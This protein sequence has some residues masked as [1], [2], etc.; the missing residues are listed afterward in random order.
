ML[1]STFELNSDVP[2]KFLETNFGAYDYEREGTR[3]ILRNARAIEPESFMP[4]SVEIFPQLRIALERFSYDGYVGNYHSWLEYGKW[5]YDDLI[6]NT[7]D[8][9]QATKDMVIAMTANCATS[10]EKA[11]CIYRYVQQ[12]TRYISIQLGIGGWKPMSAAQV[13]KLKYGDCKALTNYTA[14]LLAVVGIRSLYT[15]VYANS[16]RPINYL[17]DFPSSQGNHV[18]LCLPDL[19]DTTWLECTSNT[20]DFGYLGSFTA[21]RKGLAIGP[22][23]GFIICTPPHQAQP[24]QHLIEINTDRHTTWTRT[25][26]GD[27]A[28]AYASL[29]Q[30]SNDLQKKYLKDRYAPLLSK[31]TLLD[32]D[33]YYDR[34][35]RT[36]REVVSA[37]AVGFALSGPYLTL[38]LNEFSFDP[39]FHDMQRKRY[40]AVVEMDQGLTMDYRIAMPPGYTLGK[41][42]EDINLRNKC[43]SFE[44]V[45]Y[46]QDDQLYL[47]FAYQIKAGRYSG[48]DMHH[49]KELIDQVHADKSV[50]VIFRKRE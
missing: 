33:I 21:N 24:E 12:T 7:R 22:E 30:Y 8:L 2:A 1:E 14:A 44:R 42:V 39:S 10:A 47:R 40:P 6:K 32:F 26:I 45:S 43:G 41:A 18:I 49:L 37:P 36:Y 46:V 28:M 15:E 16:S 17:P 48:E 35:S 13:D 38:T 3:F 20:N 34:S 50:R 5:V 29:S 4:P 25:I 23:G 9:P 19:P 11:A 27:E 31:A